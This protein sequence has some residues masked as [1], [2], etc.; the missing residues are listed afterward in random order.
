MGCTEEEF[1]LARVAAIEARILAYETA[2]LAVGTA[3]TSSYTF[4]DG[5]TRQTVTRHNLT[6]LETKLQSLLNARS[7]LLASLGRGQAFVRPG[8]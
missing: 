4:D 6:E 7:T 1:T 5:Q 2:V 8:F 3:G